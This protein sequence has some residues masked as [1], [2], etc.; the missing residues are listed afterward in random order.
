MAGLGQEL[1]DLVY[2]GE[3]DDARLRASPLYPTLR[4]ILGPTTNDQRPTT[5]DE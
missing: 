2:R 3:A 1:A 5:N 4:E